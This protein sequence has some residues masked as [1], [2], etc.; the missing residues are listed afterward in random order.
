MLDEREARVSIDD[1]GEGFDTSL[2]DQL[3]QSGTIVLVYREYASA[4]KW[5]EAS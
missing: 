2:L 4:W 5:L 3:R 1:D